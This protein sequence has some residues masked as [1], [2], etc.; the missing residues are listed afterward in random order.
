MKSTSSSAA[1]GLLLFAG[2]A[3][4]CFPSRAGAQLPKP[5]T[6]E[7]VACNADQLRAMLGRSAAIFGPFYDDRTA[8][9]LFTF[10]APSRDLGGIALMEQT[11]KNGDVVGP[12][13]LLSFSIS[14]SRSKLLRNPERRQL[15]TIYLLRDR[16]GSDLGRLEDAYA[17]AVVV[18]PTLEPLKNDDPNTLLVIDN[19]TPEEGGIAG[20]SKVGRG[21]IQILD[22]CANNFSEVD[23]HVFNVLA[24]TVRATAYTGRRSDNDVTLLHKLAS[25]YRGEQAAVISGGVRT[26]YRID[27]FPVGSGQADLHRVSLEMAIDIGTDGSLGDATL[28]VLPAC[29]SAA[30]RHCTSATV[31]VDVSVIRPMFGNQT[32]SQPAPTVCANGPAGCASEVSFSFADTLAGTTWLQP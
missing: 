26:T 8:T 12:E 30:D 22:H 21:L 9:F 2:L 27:L 24:R 20:D 29:A 31:E 1:T 6:A 18:D 16:P 7:Q 19:L 10:G 32:W 15:N 17:M 4:F 3:A 11:D 14:P 28:R 23:L 5:L 13:H 25:V